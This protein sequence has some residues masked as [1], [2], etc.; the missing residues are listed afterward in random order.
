M[1]RDVLKRSVAVSQGRDGPAAVAAFI[2]AHALNPVGLP[3]PQPPGAPHRAARGS[4]LRRT[5]P[6]HWIVLAAVPASARPRSPSRPPPRGPAA[7]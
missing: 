5:P 7:A 2:A 6:G 3:G 1:E 4:P